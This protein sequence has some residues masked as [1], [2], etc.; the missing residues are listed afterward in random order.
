MANTSSAKKAMR[1]DARRTLVNRNRISRVRTFVRRVE[2]AIAS[3]NRDEAALALKAAQPVMMR[4][5]AKGAY[6]RST[7]SRKISRLNARVK[8]LSA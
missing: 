6:H 5:S 8:A 3:G 7:I 4:A 1:R 2:E